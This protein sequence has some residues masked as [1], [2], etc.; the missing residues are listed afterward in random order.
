MLIVQGGRGHRGGRYRD[1]R[2]G[3]GSK[4]F[5]KEN[6][7][8]KECFNYNKKEHPPTS[9]PET[10]KNADDTYISSRSSQAKSVTKL[11]K[12]FKKMK[13]TFHK[14]TAATRVRL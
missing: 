6:R 7:K 8:D 13:K 11:T 2:G 12:Y 9:F 1:N 4:P 3:R 10:E 14:A 5:Y